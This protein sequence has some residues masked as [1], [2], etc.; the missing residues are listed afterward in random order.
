MSPILSPRRVAE[1]VVDRHCGFTRPDTAALYA[2]LVAVHPSTARLAQRYEHRLSHLLSRTEHPVAHFERLTGRVLTLSDDPAL[3][4]L[5][6]SKSGQA[7]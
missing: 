4:A 2:L 7:K 5:R 3:G 1:T 6:L